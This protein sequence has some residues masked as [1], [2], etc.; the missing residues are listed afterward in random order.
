M[1]VAK[2][3]LLSLKNPF[4]PSLEGC[5]LPLLAKLKFLIVVF[6][7]EEPMNIRKSG[8]KCHLYLVLKSNI[9]L[10]TREELNVA[11]LNPYD[12][13]KGSMLAHWAHL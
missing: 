9:N 5:L 12:Q 3:K 6:W 1:A 4:T 8:L 7:L 10:S 11:P 13:F 2:L